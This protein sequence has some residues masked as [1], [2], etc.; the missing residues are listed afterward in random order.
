MST[1]S[2]TIESLEQ[3]I[4]SSERII[5]SSPHGLS[6]RSISSTSIQPG[7]GLATLAELGAIWGDYTLASG[8][9]LIAVTWSPGLK[10]SDDSFVGTLQ[11]GNQQFTF[12]LIMPVMGSHT[13]IEVSDLK[14]ITS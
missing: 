2:L 14:E 3:A 12:N 10:G 13:P 5:F 6:G 1:E 9:R 7:I 4:A 11:T 8:D